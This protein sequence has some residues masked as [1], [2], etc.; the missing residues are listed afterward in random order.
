MI[1]GS[2]EKLNR[3]LI[4]EGCDTTMLKKVIRIGNKKINPPLETGYEKNSI[5]NGL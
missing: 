5:T 1:R 2:V 3:K 4:G